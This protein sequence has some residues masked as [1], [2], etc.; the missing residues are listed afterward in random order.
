MPRSRTCQ[1]NCEPNSEP[2]SVWIDVDPE[3]ELLADVVEEL[4]RGLLVAAVVDPQHS[5]PGAVVDRGELV[6]ARLAGACEGFDELDVDLEAVTGSLLLVA[7]PAALE[8]LVAL[9]TGSRFMSRR[10]R[11]RHTPDWEISTSW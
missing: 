4:D 8:G 7:L 5:Q 2:L 6:V 11:I 1:W 9:R 3:R 10:L